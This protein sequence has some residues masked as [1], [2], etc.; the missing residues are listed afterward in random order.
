VTTTNTSPSFKRSGSGRLVSRWEE[1]KDGIGVVVGLLAVMWVAWIVN[2]L[3]NYRLDSD[4]IIPRNVGHLWGIVT[5]P[6]LHASFGHIF[7]NTIPFLIL[8][9][10]IALAGVR[11]VIAVTTIAILISGAG[12]WLTASSGSE[13]IGAS[14]V[15]FGFAAYL[16]ARG[17]FS[18]RVGELVI[19]ALVGLIFG[20]SL[21][22]DLIPHSGVSWQAHL[23]GGIGGVVAA[24]LLTG[25]GER[26]DAQP[27]AQAGVTPN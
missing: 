8:G 12:V 16:V 19:G 23:F 15:V 10:V 3:D 26:S 9:S 1:A 6:F 11:R 5:A 18:R 4:G 21:L 20:L 22:S 17:I 14:G 2:A 25:P 27:T 24:A 7:G 13:T